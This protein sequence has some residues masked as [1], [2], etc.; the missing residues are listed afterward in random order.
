MPSQNR[1]GKYC[2]V[3]RQMQFH[4]DEVRSKIQAL[5]LVRSCSNSS[6]AMWTSTAAS[7]PI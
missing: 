3:K 7:S 2:S 6:S 1:G 4:P 5:R